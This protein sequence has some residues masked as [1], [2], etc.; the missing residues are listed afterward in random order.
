[1]PEA[2]ELWAFSCNFF[3]R[4]RLGFCVLFLY[5]AESAH[6]PSLKF[7]LE[8]R[9]SE[10]HSKEHGVDFFFLIAIPSAK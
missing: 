1:M 8:F 6:E 2:P 10:T 4:E 9:N 3:L 5:V 7:G